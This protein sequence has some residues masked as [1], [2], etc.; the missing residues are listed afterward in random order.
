[1]GLAVFLASGK[2]RDELTRAS[3]ENLQLLASI[4]AARL[5]QLLIDSARVVQIVA[6][7]DHVRSFA[8]DAS[9]PAALKKTVTDQLAVVPRTIP[10]FDSCFLIDTAGIGVAST[11]ERNVGQDLNFRDYFQEA[12][13]GNAFVSDLVVGKKSREPGVYFSTPVTQGDQVVGVLATKLKGE[14]VWDIVRNLQVSGGGYAMLIDQ[15]GVIIAHPNHQ[16]LYQSLTPIAPDTP[17]FDPNVRY[18]LERVEHVP[19]DGLD[20]V[21]NARTS[22]TQFLSYNDQDWVAGY[23]PMTTKKWKAIVVQPRQQFSA[24]VLGLAKQQGRIALVVAM[25]AGLYAVWRARSI[26]RPL[27][28]VSAAAKKLA[29]GDFSARAEVKSRDEVG[30]LATT[31]NAMVPQLAQTVELQRS[32]EL[33]QRIQQSLLPQSP[34]KL[35]AADIF[36]R[37]RYCDATGGDYFDFA[38]AVQDTRGNPIIAIGDVT[39]HGLGAALLMCTARAALRAAAQSEESLGRLMTHVNTVLTQDAVEDLYMTMTLMTVDCATRT[40]RYACGGH[41]PIMIFEPQTGEMTELSEG[42]IPL[43]AMPG[44]DYEQYDTADIPPGAIIF[45]GTDGIWEARDPDGEMFGKERM[46]EA[47]K[48]SLH[49]SAAGIGHAVEASLEAFLRGRSIQDDVTYVVVKLR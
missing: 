35:D 21:V 3:E 14:A 22:G 45:I 15:F 26:V 33:A 18:S 42:S 4:T 12:R 43:G 24:A 48:S 1:M 25:L 7:D 9:K 44:M 10:E 32:V 27:L 49:M 11:A 30:E 46:I 31:F 41:D 17:G 8:A 6:Q 47:I 20:Q 34:P 28:S 37:S 5:D 13:R 38:D 29:S 39:G 2:S 16:R 40:V 36:G 19:I 23:A